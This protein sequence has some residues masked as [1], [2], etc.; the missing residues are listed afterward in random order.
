MH[1]LGTRR[2]RPDDNAPE[3]AANP[4]VRALQV[5]P[6]GTLGRHDHR[7]SRAPDRRGAWQLARMDPQEDDANRGK[8][9]TRQ[10]RSPCLGSCRS[11]TVHQWNQGDVAAYST[12]LR[13]AKPSEPNTPKNY[14]PNA[15]VHEQNATLA[16]DPALGSDAA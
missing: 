2:E 11:A 8:G 14:P 10:C 16:P 9:R 3:H 15:P 4:P 7:R 6:A 13:S 12:R 5:A 1:Q